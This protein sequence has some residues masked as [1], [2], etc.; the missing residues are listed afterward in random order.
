MFGI[1]QS[2][3]AEIANLR[4]RETE[5][6]RQTEGKCGRGLPDMNMILNMNQSG[7]NIYTNIND[8]LSYPGVCVFI[9]LFNC[10]K[11]K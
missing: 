4:L 3:D 1:I 9:Q 7:Y 8:M 2:V 6:D 11:V 5:T 10:R